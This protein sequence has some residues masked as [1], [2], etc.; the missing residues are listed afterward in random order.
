[1]TKTERLARV[2]RNWY[3][4]KGYYRAIRAMNEAHWI[5]RGLRKDGVTPEIH[6]QISI[7]GFLKTIN[8]GLISPESVHIVAWL[9]DALEDYA[10]EFNVRRKTGELDFLKENELDDIELITRNAGEPFARYIE[11]QVI[12]PVASIVKGAD[13]IHNFQTMVGVFS[14]EKRTSYIEEGEKYIIPMLK[15]AKDRYPEQTNAY[16][17][18]IH[19][20]NTQ[21]E[22]LKH[23]D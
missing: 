9:H 23:I 19:V 4:G 18:V 6:H 3:E 5:H 21:I 2:L 20:L 1:M 7:A 10:D 16:Y 14:K 13:R 17:N 11:V 12:S 15:S 22:L 8:E